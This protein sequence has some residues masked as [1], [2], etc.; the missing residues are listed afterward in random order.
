MLCQPFSWG[1]FELLSLHHTSQEALAFD[2]SLFTQ[3][4]TPTLS[5]WCRVSHLGYTLCYGL[6]YSHGKTRQAM[7]AALFNLSTASATTKRKHNSKTLDW[8]L[9]HRLDFCHFFKDAL[10]SG[11]VGGERCFQIFR[12]SLL[13]VQNTNFGPSPW[14]GT[15]KVH[16]FS[17]I[18]GMNPGFV[19]RGASRGECPASGI[20]TL[21]SI[22]VDWQ[23]YGVGRCPRSR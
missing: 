11:R 2:N 13:L 18:K 10:F 23:L 6:P 5:L 20:L 1:N 15:S 21:H 16:R 12:Q 9:H 22:L 8:T 7:R 14:N 17:D 19:S 3:I 4:G